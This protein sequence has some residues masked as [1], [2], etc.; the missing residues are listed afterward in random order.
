MIS[1]A[2]LRSVMSRATAYISPAVVVRARAPF[3]PAVGTVRAEVAVLEVEDE[4]TGLRLLVDLGL[5]RR[6]IVRVD[7]LDERPA[8]QLG[9]LEPEHL[10]PSRVEADEVPLERRRADEIE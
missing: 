3:E 1:S 7:E 9:E 6:E 5:R 10:L 8:R 2:C 4:L